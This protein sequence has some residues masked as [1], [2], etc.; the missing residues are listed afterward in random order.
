MEIDSLIIDTNAYSFLNNDAYRVAEILGKTKNIY[1]TFI[2]LVELK[3]GFKKGNRELKNLEELQEFLDYS[4]AKTLFPNS[5]TLELYVQIQLS[6]H[7]KGKPIP[8]NDIWIA[9]LCLEH[10]APLLTYDAHFKH[11]DGLSLVS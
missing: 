7:E 1:I 3:Y 11:V 10:N 5:T 9:A 8:T 4:E 2:T 6:L